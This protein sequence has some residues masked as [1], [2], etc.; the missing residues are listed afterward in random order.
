[1][2]FRSFILEFSKSEKLLFDSKMTETVVTRLA[3]FVTT[4][5]LNFFNNV[6]KNKINKNQQP[7]YIYEKTSL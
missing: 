6:C 2:C 1:M 5:K 7:Q 3:R 4:L